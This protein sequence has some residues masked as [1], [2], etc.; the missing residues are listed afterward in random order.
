M[1]SAGT[2]TCMNCGYTAEWVTADFESAASAA[3]W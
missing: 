3:M 1:G 2:H